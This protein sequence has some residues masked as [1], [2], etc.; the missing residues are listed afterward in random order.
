MTMQ[1]AT[2]KQ[3]WTFDVV[4]S[5][6]NFTVRHMV[7][8][9]VRGKFTKFDGTLVMDENDPKGGRVEVAIDAATIDT[10]VDQRD[11]HLRS[12]DFFDVEHFPT[13]TF[14]S[15]RVEQAGAGALKVAGDLTMHGVT[16]PVVL[17]VDYAGSAKDPWGGVRAGF[18]A[19]ASLDRKEF[20]LTYNQLL[21]TGGVVVG[22]TVEIAI[23]AEMVKQV[24]AP[25]AVMA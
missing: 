3:Q 16:R 4:H 12:A 22:E 6:I 20:G 15:R 14:K 8:S 23:E 19:R 18:S 13:I 10:G 1:S 17:D 24:A 5:S 9:K 2:T 7:I 21:E 11:A 25:V